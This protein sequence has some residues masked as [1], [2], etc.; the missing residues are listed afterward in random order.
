M[1]GKRA[2]HIHK[3]V[4]LRWNQLS[5]RPL[6]VYSPFLATPSQKVDESVNILIMNTHTQEEMDGNF[7]SH[8]CLFSNHNQHIP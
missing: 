4:V 7:Y 8:L 6:Q 5:Y 3:L 1:F 2:N